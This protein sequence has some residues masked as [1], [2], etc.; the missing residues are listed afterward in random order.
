MFAIQQ[1][2]YIKLLWV[3]LKIDFNLFSDTRPE[4]LIKNS[5]TFLPRGGTGQIEINLGGK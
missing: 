2:N 4:L 5:L 1:E 3:H